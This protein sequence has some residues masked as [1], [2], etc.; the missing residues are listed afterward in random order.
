M[1]KGKITR[2]AFLV[3]LF[4]VTLLSISSILRPIVKHNEDFQTE[5]LQELYENVGTYDDRKIVLYDT[6]PSAAKA[7]AEQ[8]N[9]SLRITAS[10]N[11]ATLT[12]PEGST[13]RDV[14]ANNDNLDILNKLSIDYYSKVNDIEEEIPQREALASLYEPSDEYYPL[15]NYLNYLNLGDTWS[16]YRGLGVTVAIIDTGIDTDH[17][18][19]LGRISTYSYNATEDKIVKDYLLE[20]HEYDWSLIEDV[21]GHGTKVAGVIASS[22]NNGGIAGIAPSVELLIIKCESSIDGTFYNTS[23]LVFGL[24]YAIEQDVDIVN[25]SFGVYSLQNPFASAT[26]LAV[27]SDIICVAAAGNDSSAQL[28]YPAADVNV[29]GV[30]ALAAESWDLAYYSNYGENV[31]IV[32]PGSTYTTKVGAVTNYRLVLQWLRR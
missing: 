23:D 18:E 32:A 7:L 29:I 28:C 1:Q 21:Q 3:F 10:G 2:L 6:T 27:D 25:M 30:G 9:A 8:F 26:K 19:F 12:L 17:S 15:Q 31:N 14:F 22:M 24:Y 11:F 13:I 5:K 20:N 4:V 16:S